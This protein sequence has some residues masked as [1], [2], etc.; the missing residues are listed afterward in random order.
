MWK[1]NLYQP[2]EILLREHDTF[3]IGEHQHSFFEMAYILEGTGSFVV[4]SVNGGKE[5]HNYCAA[6][7]CLIPPNRVHMFRSCLPFR[8]HPSAF[9]A[10][11]LSSRQSHIR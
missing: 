2:V 8:E 6:D 7:L 9:R 3:P 5:H 1:E 10:Y 4:N 11:L